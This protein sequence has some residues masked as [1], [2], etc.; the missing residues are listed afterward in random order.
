MATPAP[1]CSATARTSAPGAE[2]ALAD[3][4]GGA[5]GGV[6]QGGRLVERGV[7]GDEPARSPPDAGHHHGVAPWWLGRHLEPLHVVGDDDGR[8]RA[9]RLRG[10]H[11]PVDHEVQVLG[12][13]HR[14]QEH[15]ADVLEER[16]EVDLLL[17]AAAE[18]GDHRRPRHFV[19][20]RRLR[21]PRRGHG[22]WARG[23]WYPDHSKEV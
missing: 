5:F 10:P 20:K 3:E 18:L 14:L 19:A 8:R 15:A 13:R 4:H 21:L 17:V 6:E 7:V 16:A 11:G 1:S 2:R 12:D 22:T 23:V 9:G